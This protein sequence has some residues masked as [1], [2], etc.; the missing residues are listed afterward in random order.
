MGLE[1]L[2]LG[3]WVVQAIVAIVLT[4]IAAFHHRWFA[5]SGAILGLTIGLLPFLILRGQG[6]AVWEPAVLI[7]LVSTLVLIVSLAISMRWM[8]LVVALLILGIPLGYR[9]FATRWFPPS[10]SPLLLNSLALVGEIAFL[11]GP[12]VC[13]LACREVFGWLDRLIAIRRSA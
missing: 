7:T 10:S 6:P 12:I 13:S 1:P 5:A 11:L 8:A 2:I 9:I 3:L 4:A